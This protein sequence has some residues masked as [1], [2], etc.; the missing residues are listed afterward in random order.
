MCGRFTLRSPGNLII[1]QFDLDFQ[2]DLKDLVPR[3]NIAPTQ[4]VPIV[5]GADRQLGFLHWGLV[6]FWS[7]DPKG[8]ARMIN[9]RS[10][11]VTTKPA[12]RNAIKKKRCLVPTDG[13][14][15]W[16]KE[17]KRKKPFWIRMQDERPFLMAGLWERWRDKSIPDSEPLE[18][19]TILTTNSNSLTSEVHDR[20]P[21]ILGPNDYGRWLDPEMQDADELTYLF[22]PYDSR[23]MRMDEVNDRVNS[24]R[25]DDEQCIELARSLF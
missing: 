5:R 6:P 21:V 10:E 23:D 19:F 8:G 25:N 13:Y 17:G 11:T 22:E 16:V 15:E 2:G 1:E 4:S 12:F 9:A 20:M 24:V 7:K 18:T 3:Y 14:F